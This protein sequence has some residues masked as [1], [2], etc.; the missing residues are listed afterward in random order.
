MERERE[1]ERESMFHSLSP[2]SVL[3]FRLLPDRNTAVTVSTTHTQNSITTQPSYY[4]T[5][6][7]THT[8][9][10]TNRRILIV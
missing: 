5:H 7:H 3:K 6:T 8:H 9:T 2:T 1:R 10:H 4:N